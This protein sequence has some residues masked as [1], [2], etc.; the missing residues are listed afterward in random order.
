MDQS[1]V[2]TQTEALMKAR[3]VLV[4]VSLAALAAA[5]S[6]KEEPRPPATQSPAAGAPAPAVPVQ[7]AAPAAPAGNL[8]GE[9]HRLR[10]NNY[11]HTP[12]TATINGEWVGQWDKD[13]YI[14]LTMVVKGKN[15]LSVEAGGEPKSQLDVSIEVKRSGN[16]VPLIS[17]DLNGKPGKH[18]FTFV[19]K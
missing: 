10:V 16:W 17:S 9:E 14:P 6:K 1:A 18:D 7:A 8:A 5:C 15:D 4:A 13:A 11:P 19:A 3:R 12:V 2:P